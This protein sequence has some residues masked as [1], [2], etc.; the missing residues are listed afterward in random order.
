MRD[1]QLSRLNSG[2]AATALLA[3]FL[4]ACTTQKNS[5]QNLIVEIEATVSAAEPEA[6]KYVPEQLTDV[7]NRLAELHAAFDQKDYVGVVSGA[8][9]VLAA[10]QS[11]A[12]AAAARKDEILAALND[13]W[14]NLAA[15]VPGEV[16]SLQSRVALLSKP[17]AK[18]VKGVDADGIAA[19]MRDVTSLWSKAQAAFAAGNLNEAVTAAKD[20]KTR[21]D[22]LAADLKVDVSQP[23]GA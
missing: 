14:T 6:A 9:A 5:A 22:A 21:A 10:A 15:A 2:F 12:T 11:L 8:P 20:V 1:M 4:A 13:D 16:T 19:R 23:P 18:P 17:G 7:R 3:V